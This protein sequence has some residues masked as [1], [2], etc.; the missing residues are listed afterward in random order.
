ML[1]RG[2][3]GPG[4]WMTCPA[5]VDECSEED[6][7]QSGICTNTDGSFECVCP[8]GHR[9]GPDLAS[10]LG[11]RPLP[12]SSPTLPSLPSALLSL[13]I[14]CFPHMTSRPCPQTLMSV[15]NGDLP[16]AG[17]SAVKTLRA[18]T[19][20]CGTVILGTILALR[21]PVTVRQS[22]S[23]GTSC[24]SLLPWEPEEKRPLWKAGKRGLHSPPTVLWWQV[25]LLRACAFLRGWGSLLRKQGKLEASAYVIAPCI[26]R[27]GCAVEQHFL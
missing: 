22:P 3:A 12:V 19:A 18:P 24:W 17:L 6:L 15:V 21:A 8:P 4:W 26:L 11:E 23:S 25:A 1:S 9:A 27:G 14:L 5:D 20:V 2:G 10:C 13:L 16:C 7:C